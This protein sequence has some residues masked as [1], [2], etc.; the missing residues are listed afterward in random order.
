MAMMTTQRTKKDRAK[1]KKRHLRELMMA[2][3]S[4]V[5]RGLNH[6]KSTRTE[7]EMI[8]LPINFVFSHKF[9]T[10]HVPNISL[11][12]GINLIQLF[13]SPVLCDIYKSRL[14]S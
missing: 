9:V 2:G 5:E 10:F 11:L 7:N 3:D 1:K 12:V 8:V 6:A 4:N 13:T 14:T